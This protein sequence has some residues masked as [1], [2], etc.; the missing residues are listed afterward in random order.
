MAVIIAAVALLIALWSR[1]EARRSANAAERSAQAAEQ[2]AHESGKIRKV[3]QF[4][5]L[6]QHFLEVEHL[7]RVFHGWDGTNGTRLS[8]SKASIQHLMYAFQH[9]AEFQKILNSLK[10][11]LETP[12]VREAIKAFFQ[13]SENISI[14]SYAPH[15]L[16]DIVRIFD[17][18]KKEY[19]SI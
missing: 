7:I 12:P 8:A 2:S 11:G 19:L 17:E 5:A 10:K 18:K 4:D 9:D 6:S 3:S 1:G 15:D 13:A 16:A 14:A